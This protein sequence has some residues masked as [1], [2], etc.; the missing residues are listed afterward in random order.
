VG[1]FRRVWQNFRVTDNLALS[2]DDFDTF[3]M[4]V[5]S[6]PRLPGGGGYKLDGLVA[7]KPTA[8]GRPAQNDNRLD[9]VY[10][11]QTEHWDGVDVGFDA[12]LG[13]G[14]TLQAGTSTGRTSENDCDIMSK[15]PEFQT[16]N[17]G[18]VNALRP[19]GFCDRKTPWQTQ[20]KGYAVYS[21]PKVDVQVSGTFRS[22]PGDVMRASFNAS[23]AYL[24]ANSTLGR[25]LAG[26][27]PNLAIDVVAPN[28]IYLDRRNELDMRF[29]KVL[30][31]GK[32]RSI[33]S[34]DMFNAVN[35]NAVLSANQNFAATNAADPSQ[36]RPTSILGARTFKFSV[37]FDY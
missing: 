28:E 11:K 16:V 13:G 6:D 35:S 32:A 5:P 26:G 2:A 25:T 20:V 24:A 19:R 10:G 22:V 17:L 31:F 14:L 15:I 21:V 37:Q 30:R 1:Y 34:I 12:R 36:F 8:F 7:L 18:G 4:T 3:S 9:S 29:G 23:N 27:A 33:V